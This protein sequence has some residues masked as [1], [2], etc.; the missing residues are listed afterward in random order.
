VKKYLN[1]NDRFKFVELYFTAQSIEK[2]KDEDYS[3]E[4]KKYLRSAFT[5]LIKVLDEV[6]K[7]YPR[8]FRTFYNDMEYYRMLVLPKQQAH[9]KLDEFIEEK[10]L[11]M[12]NEVCDLIDVVIEMNCT[13][14]EGKNECRLKKC[15]EFYEV[16]A[17]DID[18][19][20]CKWR[21]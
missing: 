11:D 2:L 16:E 5:Y 7:Q 6:N 3:A 17:V 13:G 8:E 20:V 10:K 4:T 15:L 18:D 19:K 14:C 21:L 12:R 9:Q 1:S